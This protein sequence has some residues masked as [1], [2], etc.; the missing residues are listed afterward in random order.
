MI[1]ASYT[2]LALALCLSFPAYSS[3]V[4]QPG[5]FSDHRR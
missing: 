3:G 4:N 5:L 1:P 2:V